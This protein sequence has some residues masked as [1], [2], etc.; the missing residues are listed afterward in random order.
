MRWKR[1][2]GSGYAIVLI[3]SGALIAG[4]VVQAGPWQLADRLAGADLVLVTAAVLLYLLSIAV[5]ALRWHVLL[6]S[7]RHRVRGRVVLSQYA[8]GQAINDLTP[9]KVAGEGA[10]IWGVHRAEGVPIGT[11]LA[12]VVA[13]KVMDLVLVTAVLVAS[14]AV[15]YLSTPTGSWW[16]LAAVCGLVAGANLA[17]IV[18]LRRP[19]IV[20]WGGRISNRVARRFRGGRYADEVGE[21]VERTIDSFDQ[22][23]RG[24]RGSDRR[25]MFLA[26]AL[27]IP[28]WALEFSRL[29]L[30]MAALG[31]LASLPAVVVASSLAMTFQVFLPGGS[32]NITVIA[33]IFARTGVTLTTATAAGLL[34]V[35]TSIWISVPIALVAL[36]VASRRRLNEPASGASGP[37]DGS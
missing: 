4:L 34:S 28:V 2:P 23:R 37:R 16:P 19:D 10:R 24:G 32:G 29:A 22:A 12:T 33:D 35:A 30:I 21:K 1:G 14:V 5:R 6:R 36:A 20:E 18:V 31:V 8:V 27:T 25:W 17:V 3:F 13:E 7:A 9:I 26:A 11:G 15:L